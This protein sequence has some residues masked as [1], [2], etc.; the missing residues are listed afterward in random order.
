MSG[1][2]S[3]MTSRVSNHI[4]G[5]LAALLAAGLAACSLDTPA[6]PE[7]DIEEG[8]T[9]IEGHPQWSTNSV[10][11][12]DD[13]GRFAFISVSLEGGP[14]GPSHF[15]YD[16]EFSLGCPSEECFPL[17]SQ[18]FVNASLDIFNL[19]WSPRGALAVFEGSTE[20]DP[21]TWIYTY[22]PQGS[23][24]RWIRGHDPSFSSDGGLVFYVEAGR[25][26]IHA[27]N[28][29]NG[30]DFLERDGIQAAAHPRPSPDG[31]YVA[32][33]AYTARGAQIYVYERATGN[34]ADAVSDP[35][36]LN[37]TTPGRD[38]IR[39][40]YPDWSP[41]GNIIAYRGQLREGTARDGIFLTFW[42]REPE[43]PIALVRLSPGRQMTYLRWHRSGLYLLAIID[44]DVYV[45]TVP[46]SYHDRG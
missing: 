37:S 44:G 36:R 10:S 9:L 33:S 22:Q 15:L 1:I 45:Y 30:G 21:G 14:F 20:G 28:H 32:Y 18:L 39:D 11:W 6:R 5:S 42:K 29:S 34:L 8:F 4:H 41:G 38:G 7:R 43:N 26:A 19:D 2:D 27:F 23:P 40:D 31:R 16:A 17:A 12:K 46:E 3:T 13:A 25:D 35:D 24:R